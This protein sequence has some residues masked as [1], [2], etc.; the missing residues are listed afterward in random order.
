MHRTTSNKFFICRRPP[1]MC[2]SLSYFHSPEA[3]ASVLPPS[4]GTVIKLFRPTS[5]R[6]RRERA[7]LAG[8]KPRAAHPDQQL[9]FFGEHLHPVLHGIGYPDVPVRVNGNALGP[10]EVAGAV[11]GFAERAVKLAVRIKDFH[12]VVQGV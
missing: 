5:A 7:E 11:A 6:S 1:V 2:T 8:Q 9:A 10:S 12:P 4:H 3:F